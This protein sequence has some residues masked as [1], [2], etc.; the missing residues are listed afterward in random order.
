MSIQIR[1]WFGPWTEVSED[2]A[3]RFV[4][5]F[6]GLSRDTMSGCEARM[7]NHLRGITVAELFADHQDELPVWLQEARA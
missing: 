2:E 4:R 6:G 5:H 7:A 1:A 3:R